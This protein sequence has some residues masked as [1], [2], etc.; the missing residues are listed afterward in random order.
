VRLSD[1]DLYINDVR[2]ALSNAARVIVYQDGPSPGRAL[3]TELTVRDGQY[4]VVG[5]N[6]ANSYDSRYWGFVPAES[7]LGRVLVCYWPPRR[8]GR[9]K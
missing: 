5:D 4:F 6:S 3:K 2:V 1:G 8:I 9:V 7:I